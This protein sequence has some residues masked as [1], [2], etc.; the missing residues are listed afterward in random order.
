MSGIYKPVQPRL[1][2]GH[3]LTAGLVFDD[4]YYL[5]FGLTSTDLASGN[6]GTF[7]GSTAPNWITNGP[8]IALNFAG[9][10]AYMDYPFNSSFNLGGS[11][12]SIQVIFNSDIV[13]ENRTIVTHPISSVAHSSPY[14]AY[15]MQHQGGADV[16][17][18][19]MTTTGNTGGATVVSGTVLAGVT[20]NAIATY[21][22]GTGGLMYLNND[23]PTSNT[24]I[25]GTIQQAST[26]LRVSGVGDLSEQ[27]DGRV[28]LIRIWNRELT[29][30]EVAL[31]QQNPWRIY[32][33][34]SLYN[35]LRPKIFVPGIAR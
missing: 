8:G 6:V 30:A 24:G 5:G 19:W 33:Q 29:A 17:R 28:Y 9:L 14:F 21:K 7:A 11:E 13:N 2:M 22:N 1:S 18:L 26:V 35:R 23:A 16:I 15:A 27:H 4:P 20:N 10:N 31:L 25:T 12:M 34:N 32:S 3:P